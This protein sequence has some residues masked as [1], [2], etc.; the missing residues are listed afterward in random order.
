[1]K[2]EGAAATGLLPPCVLKSGWGHPAR[3]D[4]QA[5]IKATKWAGHP[6][7]GRYSAEMPA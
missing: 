3:Q 7:K 2:M 1:M 6:A 4:Q 5:L